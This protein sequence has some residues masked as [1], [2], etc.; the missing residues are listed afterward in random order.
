MDLLGETVDLTGTVQWLGCWRPNPVRRN[1]DTCGR[2]HYLQR[3]DWWMGTVT[4]SGHISPEAKHIIT[5]AGQ[6]ISAVIL[7]VPAKALGGDTGDFASRIAVEAD[8]AE[9]KV[10]DKGVRGQHLFFYELEAR[11][12][13]TEFKAP[14][15]DPD[16]WR[17]DMKEYWGCDIRLP[18]WFNVVFRR[19]VRD[20]SPFLRRKIG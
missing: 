8:G 9:Q 12:W 11:W 14:K 3:F 7:H 15:V 10:T 13:H 18:Q 6:W 5:P 1:W 19:N 4:E 20:I 16:E 2:M 17:G